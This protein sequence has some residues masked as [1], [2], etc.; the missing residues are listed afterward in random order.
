MVVSLNSRLESNKEEEEDDL[1]SAAAALAFACLTCACL[2]FGAWG[3]GFGFQ[4]LGFRVYGLG[5]RGS[6]RVSRKRGEYTFIVKKTSQKQCKA[7]TAKQKKMQFGTIKTV[8]ARSWPWLEPLSGE[9][10]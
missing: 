4:G 10:P 8:T 9:S 6:A 5:F 7:N 2:G 1:F 3:L